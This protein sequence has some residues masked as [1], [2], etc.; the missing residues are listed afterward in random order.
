[1][2][3]PVTDKKHLEENQSDMK[4][5]MELMIMK[6]QVPIYILLVSHVSEI[7][8]GRDLLETQNSSGVDFANICSD[9]RTP[10]R[11]VKFH[12]YMLNRNNRAVKITSC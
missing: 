8:M 2:A 1:M 12:L 11:P 9:P 3:E 10:R 7:D 5:R 4:T 6:I